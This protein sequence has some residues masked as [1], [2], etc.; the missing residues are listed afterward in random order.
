MGIPNSGNSDTL[1]TC[2]LDLEFLIPTGDLF[3]G[4]ATV[5]T[6]LLVTTLRLKVVFFSPGF[7]E[8]AFLT[9]FQVSQRSQFRL[10]ASYKIELVSLSP[11]HRQDHHHPWHQA[12]SPI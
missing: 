9:E 2:D 12:L 5:S 7:S 4:R 3:L 8:D 6:S 10:S 11:Q 1:A